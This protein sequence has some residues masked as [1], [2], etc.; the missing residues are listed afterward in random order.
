MKRQWAWATQ[1]FRSA[2]V[3]RC[4]LAAL[5]LIAGVSFATSQWQVLAV[6]SFALPVLLLGIRPLHARPYRLQ[7]RGGGKVGLDVALDEAMTSSDG[8][9]RCAAVLLEL[10]AQDKLQNAWGADGVE[11]IMA[12]L[13]DRLCS[14]LRRG[15]V[16]VQLDGNR[17]ALA[18]ANIRTPELGAIISL[19]ERLQKAASGSIILDD[20][21]TY[22][23]LS[24]GF[25]LEHRA[26]ERTAQSLRRAAALAL[27]DAKSKGPEG[28][29]GY[30]TDTPTPCAATDSCQEEVLEA[31]QSGQIIAWFQPQISTE[32]GQVT[33]FE[34]L[35]R[36]N[37]PTRGILSPAGFLS[38]MEDANAMEQLSETMLQHALRAIRAWDASGFN[39]ASV[40]VNFS[41]QD[42][43]NPSLVERIKWDVDRFEM[44]PSRLTVEI[45]ET[46]VSENEDDMITRN[47][48]ALGSQGYNIDLDDFGTGHASLANIRRFKVDRIK[49]DRSFV[50]RADDDPEQ[51]RMINAIV[52]MAEQMG[53]KTLA[54][55][56]ETLGE[57]SILSQLGCTHMQGYAIARPMPFE[58]TL[59]WLKEH[60]SRLSK[61][62]Y[63]PRRAG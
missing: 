48:R 17:F 61:M 38:A 58:Q 25:C 35:A 54:E 28:L 50:T 7:L 36:W 14:V 57:K 9:H 23:T 43:R 37:H 5:P 53:V 41:T 13:A 44:V 60:Q 6:A 40:A 34:A 19:I 8:N 29:R 10:D 12:T 11:T 2:F 47:I 16:I 3:T 46:V 30:S 27:E 21:S 18:L 49:I 42:L 52:S 33:G 63:V 20:T 39:I 31:L 24:A 51:R 4:G 15:D 26:P 62:N 56:V 45:L 32:T 22:V 55:G 1:V 59:V